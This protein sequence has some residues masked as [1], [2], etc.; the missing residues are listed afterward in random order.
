MVRSQGDNVGFCPSTRSPQHPG[1]FPVQCRPDT[2][3]GVD[4]GH[5]ASMTS[6]CPAGRIT[7]RLVCDI[8]QQTTHQVCIAVSGPQGRVHGGHVSALGPREG[9]PVYIPAIQD[10][11]SM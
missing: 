4:D 6:I 3:H 8:H 2:G 9:P 7:G 11:H 1:R 5:V 10:G